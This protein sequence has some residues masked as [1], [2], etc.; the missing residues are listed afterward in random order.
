MT[1][2]SDPR[3][4]RPRWKHRAEYRAFRF[5]AACANALPYRMALALAWIVA[6][7]L[8]H[9]VRFRRRETVRRVRAV[10]GVETLLDRAQWIAWRS[11]RNLAFNAVEMLRV[12]RFD[13]DALR[14]VIVD[15]D[16]TMDAV[17]TAAGVPDGKGGAVIGIPHMGNWDLMGSACH[18]AGAPI[19]SVAARQRNPLMNDFI[20]RLRSG[21]GMDILE[22]GAGTLRQVVE[23]LRSGQLFAILPDTRSREPDLAIPFLGGEANL[24]RGMAAFARA[25]GVPILPVVVLREGW[26]RFRVRVHAP[27][28]SDPALD[29][30]ADYERM[31]RAVLGIIDQ[32]IRE[33]PDQWFWY[34]K[35][36][37]LEPLE[38]RHPGSK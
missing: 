9:L 28:W 22:R 2:T 30:V 35:R 11:L 13:L 31:T 33:H 21:H 27:V 25:A 36:W 7:V 24:A 19:F 4:L 5:L 1:P 34:N 38:A 17:R 12:R 14:R 23:R 15:F 18:L 6:A 20:N 32:A 8:F 10:F 26:A 16:A 3:N 37:V 29:K